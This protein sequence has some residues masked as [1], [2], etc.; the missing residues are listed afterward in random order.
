MHTCPSG[1]SKSSPT[2]S[3]IRSANF[4]NA[5][6]EIGCA[7]FDVEASFAAELAESDRILVK[8][9]PNSYIRGSEDSYLKKF[10]LL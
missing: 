8:N 5:S 4:S 10:Y 7:F 9:S 3:F 1:I 2:S 6:W